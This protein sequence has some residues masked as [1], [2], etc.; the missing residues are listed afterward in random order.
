MRWSLVQVKLEPD[1]F[2]D[3]NFKLNQ[4]LA[5]D[6]K[7]FQYLIVKSTQLVNYFLLT[8]VLD[9]TRIIV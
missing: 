3:F 1:F 4:I 6:R 2:N 5:T 8:K 7:W 9:G